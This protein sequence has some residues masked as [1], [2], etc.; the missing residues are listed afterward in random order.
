MAMSDPIAEM[1]TKIRNAQMAKHEEITVRYSKIKEEIL[2]ILKNDGFILDYKVLKVANKSDLKIKLK[3]YNKKPVISGIVR[4][5][6]PGRRIY[7]KA[8]ELQPVMNNRG[9]AIISTSKGLMP[10]RKAKKLGIGGE[11]LLKVW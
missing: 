2:K 10:G 5:S 11:Y 8:E 6:K 7:V 3:Y 4:V 1:L 9:V